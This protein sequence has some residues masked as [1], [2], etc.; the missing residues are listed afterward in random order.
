MMQTYE[1]IMN[2]LLKSRSLGDDF[3]LREVTRWVV[4]C[5]H[6]GVQLIGETPQ[7]EKAWEHLKR[8]VENRQCR[9]LNCIS[10]GGTEK[11]RLA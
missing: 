7:T 10:R 4:H 3:E 9:N 8:T 6:C 11:R 2:Q 1:E 5:R